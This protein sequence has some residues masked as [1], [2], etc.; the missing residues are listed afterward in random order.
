LISG[1]LSSQ[2]LMTDAARAEVSM[3]ARVMLTPSSSL[4]VMKE[5]DPVAR[6]K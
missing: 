3:P 4:F 1:F 6:M 2:K 5:S